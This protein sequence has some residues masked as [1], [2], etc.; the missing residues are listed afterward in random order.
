MRAIYT[1]RFHC[2]LASQEVRR[3]YRLDRCEYP[4]PSRELPFLNPH[5]TRSGKPF[6]PFSAPI[7]IRE[8]LDIGSLLRE[9]VERH[10]QSL[11]ER[12]GVDADECELEGLEDGVGGET[13]S[14][15]MRVSLQKHS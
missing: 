14:L 11:E 9:A 6:S 7:R 10:V 13:F 2:S 12:A 4:L 5:K 8:D 15:M 1:T 3:L